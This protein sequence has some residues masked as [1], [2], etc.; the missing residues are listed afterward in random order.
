MKSNDNNYTETLGDLEAIETLKSL[1]EALN[2][3]PKNASAENSSSLLCSIG[4]IKHKLGKYEALFNDFNKALKS[5]PNQAELNLHK[6]VTLFKLDRDEEAVKCYKIMVKSSPDFQN[7]FLYNGGTNSKST[8]F[9]KAIEYYN[10]HIKCNPGKDALD[11]YINKG[12]CLKILNKFEKAIDSYDQAL[13]I[14]SLD[15]MIY[16]NKAGALAK[17]GKFQEALYACNKAKET[18]DPLIMIKP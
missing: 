17:S 12:N 10:M 1:T 13:K 4:A 8:N 14:D 7:V 2:K 11:A 15:S 16:L 9:E 6:S 5:M 3:L 18:F